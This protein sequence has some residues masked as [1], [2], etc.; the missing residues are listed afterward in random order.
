MRHVRILV[1]VLTLSIMG[2]GLHLVEAK[3]KS[4]VLKASDLLGMKVEGADGK[5]LGDIKDMVVDPEDGSIEYVVLDFGGIAGIGD[6]YFAVPWE[7]V[8]I[9]SDNK[10][11]LVSTTKKDLKEAP[12]FDKNHWPDL[13]DHGQVTTIYEFYEVPIPPATNSSAGSKVERQSR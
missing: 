8:E 4:G 13:S 2:T 5:K 10:K 1:A 12:G 9:S 7:T 3:D 6:K 11:L